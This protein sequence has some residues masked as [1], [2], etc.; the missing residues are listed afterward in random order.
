MLLRRLELV[1]IR[2]YERGVLDLG[3]GTTVLVGPNAHGKTNL[4]E[5][6]YRIATGGSHRV[7]SDAPIVRHGAE[8]GYIRA[9]LETDAGRAR[10]VELELRPGRGSRARV[11]GQDV[12]RTAD[13]VGVLRVVL[14]APEDLAIVRGDPSERRRFLDEVL[15]Q[16]RPTYA[17]AKSDYERVLRQRNQLLRTARGRGHDVDATIEVWT[18]QLVT[19]GSVLTAAR[20]AAVHALQGPTDGFYR[21]LAD[22]PEPVGMAY[23]ASLGIEVEGTAGEPTPPPDDLAERFRAQLALRSDDERAR[24]VTLVGPHRDDLDLSLRGLPTRGY[25]SHGQMWSLALALRLATFE[26]LADV[27]ERPVV[28]LDDVFAELDD[29]RRERLATACEHREQVVVTTAVERD[30]PLDGAVVDVRM[31]GGSST[32]VRRSD[33]TIAGA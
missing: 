28:L 17:A 14:F 23:R 1:D 18:D 12:R 9:T 13:A 29:A 15:V 2:S 6:A 27:G 33:A 8:V 20:I 5:A 16:R 10:T 26:V 3:A 21:D 19:T 11:D 24:G 30:V 22:R 31:D 25:A 4:L 32:A 7:S